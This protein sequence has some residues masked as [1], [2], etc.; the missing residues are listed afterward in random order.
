MSSAS[1]LKESIATMVPLLRTSTTTANNDLDERRTEAALIPSLEQSGERVVR[2]P[3]EP[4]TLATLRARLGPFDD[5]TLHSSMRDVDTAPDNIAAISKTYKGL[6]DVL[7]SIYKEIC[8]DDLER[9]SSAKINNVD[10]LWGMLGYTIASVEIATRGVGASPLIE[11]VPLRTGTLYDQIPAQMQTFLRVASDTILAYTSNIVE[12]DVSKE[13]NATTL[14]QMLSL[15]RLKQIFV[16]VS[17]EDV[18]RTF[19]AGH[20]RLEMHDTAPILEDDPFMIL[21]ELSLHLVPSMNMEIYPL[22]RVLLLAEL[23]KTV[24]GLCQNAK[25]RG[26][27]D[28]QPPRSMASETSCPQKQVDAATTFAILVMNEL[29]FS[30]SKIHET[31]SA[32]G[33]AQLCTIVKFFALPFLRRAV[34]L[35]MVRFGYIVQ[36]NDMQHTGDEADRLLKILGLPTFDHLLAWT[37]DSKNLVGNWCKQF[38]QESDAVALQ[39]GS[40]IEISLDMPTPLYL[41]ALPKNFER[42]MDES[43]R[44]E[45]TKCNSIPS[46]PALC[47]LCGTFVCFQSF[48]CTVDEEG[49][50]NLHMAE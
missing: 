48:C 45:C 23:T 35:M 17:L 12:Q 10:L 41:I 49:E 18:T 42:L 4:L 19:G 16:N 24:V 31:L 39:S 25:E 50:C 27:K 21:V 2:N 30:K 6:Y 37:P 8:G 38:T 34:L 22:M 46:E 13:S 14:L 44:R 43:M 1:K 47:L 32:Y 26:G 20:E 9:E 15:G 29:K 3:T 7:S 5:G 28:A 36:G 33:E 40:P 11:E